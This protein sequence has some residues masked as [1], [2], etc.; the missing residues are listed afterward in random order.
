[1]HLLDNLDFQVEVKEVFE[2][3]LENYLNEGKFKELSDFIKKLKE[4]HVTKNN[5]QSNNYKLI[6]DY[7]DEVDVDSQFIEY[8]IDWIKINYSAITTSDI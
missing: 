2:L 5:L 6:T 4:Y 8:V 1:M 3:L 7:K